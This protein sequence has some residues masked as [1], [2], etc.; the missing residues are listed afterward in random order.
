[1]VRPSA[2][3]R[4]AMSQP[5]PRALPPRS[6]PGVVLATLALA[7]SHGAGCAATAEAGRLRARAEAELVRALERPSPGER[8]RAI[9]VAVRVDD[10]ALS[11][12]LAAHL[13]DR[14]PLIR[15]TTAAALAPHLDEAARI[16]AAALDGREPELKRTALAG[17]RALP[18]AEARLLGLLPDPDAALRRAAV[19]ALGD[20]LPGPALERALGDVD[21]G[22]RLAALSVVRAVAPNRLSLIARSDDLLL[23]LRAAVLARIPDRAI[24]VV[25]RAAAA[26]RAELRAAAMNAAG[27]LGEAGGALAARLFTDAE[28]GVRL[29]AA[30]AVV[31]AYNA[32]GAGAHSANARHPAVEAALRVFADA[33]VGER[34]L[35]AADELARLGDPRGRAVLDAEASDKDA[36]RRVESLRLLATLPDTLPRFALALDDPDFD[37]RLIAAE[38]ILRRVIGARRFALR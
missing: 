28:L 8:R 2:A 15:V 9:Q 5:R 6:S 24:A 11:A 35:E 34:R 20:R 37:V 19:A 22:V 10:P 7:L 33:L 36:G 27:E 29:A 32:T 18:D 25:A 4:E 12:R 23:A 16:V 1:M 21:L 26:P 14:D 38:S 17:I 13:G 31:H 3:C 30:R